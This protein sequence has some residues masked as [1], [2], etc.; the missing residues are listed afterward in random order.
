[1]VF[2]QI[3]HVSGSNPAANHVPLP[4]SDQIQYTPSFRNKHFRLQ[5]QFVTFLSG[6]VEITSSS[7]GSQEPDASS[8]A[9]ASSASPRGADCP[10]GG[11][12]VSSCS[13]GRPLQEI[14]LDFRDMAGDEFRLLFPFIPLPRAGEGSERV[15]LGRGK[16]SSMSRTWLVHS[17]LCTHI[18]PQ[19]KDKTHFTPSFHT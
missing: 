4:K 12:L 1:M 9:T 19:R 13:H 3:S 14:T 11:E 5:A 10:L 8:S 7:L 6:Q 15:T 18:P 16:I 2:P 17:Q